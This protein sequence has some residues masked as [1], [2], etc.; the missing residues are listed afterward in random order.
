MIGAIH[1]SPVQKMDNLIL[2]NHNK[3]WGLDDDLVE[4]LAK[5]AL[6]EKG[7]KE[8][9]GI[10]YLFCGTKKSQRFEC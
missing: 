9:C 8:R 4:R 1:E 10:K 5:K 7:Y 6:I 3:N 2:I